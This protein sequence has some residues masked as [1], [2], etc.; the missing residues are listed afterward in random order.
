[1][2]NN[3]SFDVAFFGVNE[4]QVKVI[5]TTKAKRIPT[6]LEGKI[7]Q[8][9]K[10]SIKSILIKH[11]AKN[12]Q[13]ETLETNGKDKETKI[14]LYKRVEKTQ[15]YFVYSNSFTRR[16]ENDKVYQVFHQR[17]H[18]RGECSCQG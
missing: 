1:M 15:R 2:G 16:E 9:V 6:T 14:Q 7:K 8:E 4:K 18:S 17:E 11:G 10:E 3:K 5:T 13:F 12:Y